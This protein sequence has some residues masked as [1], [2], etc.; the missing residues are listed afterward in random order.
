MESCRS[1]SLIQKHT[2]P[3]RSAITLLLPPPRATSTAIFSGPIG[4]SLDESC[5]IAS[6]TR[7][8]VMNWFVDDAM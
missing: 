6:S 5:P 2:R 1:R 4:L 3:W 7:L 8:P